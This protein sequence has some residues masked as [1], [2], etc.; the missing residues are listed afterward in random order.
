L[1]TA[2]P[3][4]SPKRGERE[5]ETVEKFV[6]IKEHLPGKNENFIPLTRG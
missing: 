1:T 3:P 2:H 5:R 4:T 6:K